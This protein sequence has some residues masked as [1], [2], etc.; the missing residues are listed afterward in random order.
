MTTLPPELAKWIEDGKLRRR[1]AIIGSCIPPIFESYCKIFHPFEMTQDETIFLEIKKRFKQIK[2]RTQNDLLQER[3]EWIEEYNSKQWDFISWKT[4]ADK[5]GLVFHKQINQNVF[6]KKIDDVIWGKNLLLP[7]EGHL[8]RQIFI[9]LLKILKI[10]SDS[11]EVF[12]YQMVPHS[13]YKDNRIDDLV[14]C[15][16]EEV[17]EY[18]NADFIGYLYATDKSWIVFTDTDLTFTIV[19][20]QQKLIDNIIASDIEALECTSTTRVDDF[21]DM[22]N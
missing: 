6:I 10:Q 14:K 19:G 9:K 5:Y 8:R 12:I 16:Y 2:T 18:F 4:M 15:N 20:G 17:L 22:I 13:I 1:G 7:N 3:I 11:N 21:S